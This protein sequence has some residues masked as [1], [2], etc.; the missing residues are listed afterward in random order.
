M[1]D[2]A[3]DYQH[4]SRAEDAALGADRDTLCGIA[5]P[6]LPNRTP[7]YDE[8]DGFAPYMGETATGPT[9]YPRCE[10]C[11]AIAVKRG[12]RA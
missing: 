2:N 5:F 1:T 4:L 6:A 11:A 9:S 8:R 3:A 12:A 7:I 10:R